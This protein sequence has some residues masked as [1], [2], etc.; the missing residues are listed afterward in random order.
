MTLLELSREE[1]RSA[2]ENGKVTITVFGLG[3][4]GLPLAAILARA[5]A[6]V[7]GVDLRGEV[8][9]KVNRGLSP[10]REEPGLAELV[11]EMVSAQRLRATKDGVEA[12]KVSDVSIVVVPVVLDRYN[13]PDLSPILDVAEKISRGIRKGHVFITETTLPP[14]TTRFLA[15]RISKLSGLKAGTDFGFAHA[16]ER[17]MSGRMIMDITCSYPRIVGASDPR[18][19]QV[20]TGLYEAI[21]KR[22]VIRASSVEVAE[23]TK[24]F[25]GVYRDVNIALANELARYAEVMGFDALEAIN[26]ANT[27]PYSH[28][29]KPGAGVGGHC[30]PVY[31]Y[32]LIHTA[33][34]RGLNLRILEEARRVNDSMP[35]HL[36]YIVL[37]ALN[38]LGLPPAN[39]RVLVLGLT[40]RPGVK[41]YYKSPAATIIGEL[42]SWG[43]GVY[44]YDPITEPEIIE[45]FKA[46][47]WKGEPADVAVIVTEYQEFV[48][49]FRMGRIRVRAI[50]DG[51]RLLDPKMVEDGGMFYFGIGYPHHG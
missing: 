27:Q 44:A 20:V 30:I 9:E 2:V 21:N 38:R 14:G 36:T 35:Y 48:E 50:V 51:R 11:E 4:L 17:T 49:M 15:S 32:F 1:V 16:P 46:Q 40:Y 28:I 22:G 33:A 7:I 12:V 6:R 39:S 24:V 23:A 31:P 25:E 43:A 47:P 37:K 13:K 26:L 3:K 19:L 29:H 10:I 42:L 5:G 8:V 45:N 34:E 41:E 18:T